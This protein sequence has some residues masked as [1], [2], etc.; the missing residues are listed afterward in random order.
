MRRDP[1]PVSMRLLNGR[2]ELRAIVL[3][4]VGSERGGSCSP[5]CH[6]LDDIDAMDHPLADRSANA[7]LAI[8]H[9]TKEPAVAARD[10]EGW[11]G[12]EDTRA[13]LVAVAEQVP[14]REG[15]VIAVPRSRIV[16]IPTA[17]AHCAALCI[18]CSTAASSAA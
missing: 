6:D 7:V 5:G 12:G 4:L 2:S 9:T 16:V 14:Q 11:P 1:E 3:R 17:R 8:G 10:G 13:D 15:Q 18:R